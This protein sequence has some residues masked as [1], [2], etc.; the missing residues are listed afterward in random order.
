MEEVR[1]LAFH[2]VKMGYTS[3]VTMIL[4]VAAAWPKALARSSNTGV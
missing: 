1:V 3:F 4:A 2:I